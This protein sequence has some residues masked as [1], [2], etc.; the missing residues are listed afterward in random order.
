[1]CSSDLVKEGVGVTVGVEVVD[2]DTLERSAGK[3]QRLKD[4]RAS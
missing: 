1:M 2:P 3:L 4:L